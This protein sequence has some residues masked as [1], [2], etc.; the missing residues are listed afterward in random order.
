MSKKKKDNVKVSFIGQNSH[1]VTGSCTLIEYGN[2]KILLECGLFQSNNLKK[3]YSINNRAFKF[4][5]KEI[6]YVFVNHAHIDHTGL[7]PKLYEEGCEAQ[8]ICTHN[9]L[10]FMEP[11]LIDSANIH[12]RDAETLTRTL[13]KEVLPIYLE[14]D[15]K[16]ALS[17]ARGYDFETEYKL[18]KNVSFKFIPAG[19][20]LGSA[21]LILYVTKD[22]GQTKKIL[23]TS[24]LG[25][26]KL[27]KPYVEKFKP[28]NKAHIVIGEC[29][30]ND[31][32][33][34]VTKKDRDKDLEKIKAVVDQTC[35]ESKGR[36]LIPCFALDRTQYM[37][38]MLYDVFGEDES[39][40]IPVMIDSPLAVKMSR[41]Y[42]QAMSEEDKAKYKAI[43]SWKNLTLI[44]DPKESKANVSDKNPKIVISSSGMLTAGRSIH[45]VKEYLP[46]ERS[47]ILFC[48]FAAI[49]SLAN[50][51]KVG[52]RQIK[53]DGKKYPNKAKMV[54]LKSFSSHMQHDD[55]I[56]YYKSINCESIY[57]VHGNMDGKLKFA[58]KLQ[59]EISKFKSTKVVCT[60]KGTSVS[61]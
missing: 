29:T 44:T 49:N 8:I 59:D 47:T 24:D 38:T 13:K 12:K 31:P 42:T 28:E 48:G 30:Y 1:E 3:D 11:L 4:K 46:D 14:D 22:S 61:L 58:K 33:R 32:L 40:N 55:L 9:T 26:I 15:A 25:N 5:P 45:Y 54:D 52:E 27:S 35:L 2:K 53:I 37:L 51:I 19:H 18:D 60:N 17:Y 20:I 7:I 23:Y 21:Q 41:L 36:V 6:D 39:F 57:L 56:A 43:M 16:K 10:L 34:S 50:I